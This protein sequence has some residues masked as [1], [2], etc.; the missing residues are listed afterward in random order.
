[1]NIDDHT[2]LELEIKTALIANLLSWNEG[3]YVTGLPRLPA[4]SADRA[5]AATI[6]WQRSVN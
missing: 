3:V 6:E 2:I 5:D 4:H 1:M